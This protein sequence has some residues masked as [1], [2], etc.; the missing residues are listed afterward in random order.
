MLVLS[1][2][3]LTLFLS[4]EEATPKDEEATPKDEEEDDKDFLDRQKCQAALASLRRAKWF[5]VS[6]ARPKS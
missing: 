2:L 5:Q 4:P 3:C 1:L 6:A